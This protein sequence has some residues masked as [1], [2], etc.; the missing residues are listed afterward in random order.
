[1]ETE[2][3][4]RERPPDWWYDN[5]LKDLYEL[6]CLSEQKRLWLSDESNVKEVSCFTE[7]CCR[8]FDDGAVTEWLQ[9]RTLQNVTSKEFSTS[10]TR[11]NA[12]IDDVDEYKPPH[13]IMA[14]PSMV[15]VRTEAKRAREL[16][17]ACRP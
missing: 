11:L 6:S 1:M 4:R 16:L 3:K 12:L 2:R 8:I 14:S 5:L 7:V 9:D 13:A 15:P 10:I 17:K